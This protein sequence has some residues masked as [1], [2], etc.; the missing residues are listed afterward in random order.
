[1]NLDEFFYLKQITQERWSILDRMLQLYTHDINE[2]FDYSVV[3]DNNGRYCI[4][5]VEKFLSDGFGYFIIIGNK[6]AGFVLL[7]NKTKPP[8][9]VFI[10]ELYILP[11]FR[12]GF[13]YRKVVFSLF[14]ELKGHV[15]FRVLKN[16]KR[17]LVLFEYLTKKYVSKVEKTC[18]CENETEFFRFALDTENILINLSGYKIH[19]NNSQK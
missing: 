13:F 16:N 9:G 14:S 11:R 17:A 5:T 7:N 3:L 4:K 8:G 12:Q 18:E 2:Y 6:Y 15:E 1:M 10:S 19:I